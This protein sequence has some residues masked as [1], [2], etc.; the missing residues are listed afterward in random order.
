MKDA[1][2]SRPSQSLSWTSALLGLP[3]SLC[4]VSLA[5]IG[6]PWEMLFLAGCHLD[7]DLFPWMTNRPC[8]ECGVAAPEDP[9]FLKMVAGCATPDTGT[10]EDMLA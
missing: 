5:M 4:L 1:A 3:E 2:A 9:A 6:L 8:R 7:P 10:V